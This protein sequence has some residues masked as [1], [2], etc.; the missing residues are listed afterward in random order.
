MLKPSSGA[1]TSASAS[2]AAATA[3]RQQL[4]AIWRKLYGVAMDFT[5]AVGGSSSSSS[6]AY[7]PLLGL[8]SVHSKLHVALMQF[9]DE[10]LLA[11][12]TR[13]GSNSSSNSTSASNSS[14]TSSDAASRGGRRGESNFSRD[15][16]AEGAGES[17]SDVSATDPAQL[18]LLALLQGASRLSIQMGLPFTM[19]THHKI[20]RI[21]A[22][23][24]PFLALEH[25]NRLV[26]AGQ[27]AGVGGSR[28]AA[29]PG[30]A[31]AP[32]AAAQ[33][34]KGSASPSPLNVPFIAEPE[35]IDRDLLDPIVEG[36]LK[37]N[38]PDVAMLFLHQLYPLGRSDHHD[39]QSAAQR[40]HKSGDNNQPRKLAE[41][42]RE[43]V[44]ALLAKLHAAE[45]PDA[46]SAAL[47]AETDLNEATDVVPDMGAYDTPLR[48][49]TVAGVA[50]QWS[51]GLAV[52]DRLRS[53]LPPGFDALPLTLP[54]LLAFETMWT[55]ILAGTD[56][57]KELLAAEDKKK[58]EEKAVR[59][60]SK[61]A[62]APSAVASVLP[63]EASAEDEEGDEEEGED[64]EGEGD[65]DPREFQAMMDMWQQ[66][67]SKLES[68]TISG[69]DI[70]GAVRAWD[71]QTKVQFR[72]TVQLWLQSI[73][74]LVEC[75]SH[76]TAW[77]RLLEM[78]RS[79]V[80]Q[81]M[82]RL[83]YD[84]FYR[85]AER[86]VEAQ[87]KQEQ[88]AKRAKAEGGAGA[89]DKG[90]DDDEEEDDDEAVPQSLLDA[91]LDPRL[92]L[93]ESLTDAQR[94]EVYHSVQESL[95][96]I[97]QRLVVFPVEEG[98]H[99]YELVRRL[100]E[101]AMAHY[102]RHEHVTAGPLWMQFKP[103]E[104]FAICATAE[105]VLRDKA[106]EEAE[107]DEEEEEKEEGEGAKKPASAP[108]AATVAPPAQQKQLEL[109]PF[110]VRQLTQAVVTHIGSQPLM[111]SQAM[112]GF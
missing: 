46:V 85:A 60:A 64:E 7:S 44:G 49:M 42:A 40:L 100:Q 109:T 63:K 110:L 37:A 3:R 38:R 89:T 95:R 59:A 84:L 86:Q 65:I 57:V 102:K 33:G 10:L 17:L 77:D 79:R 12:T 66:L 52:T 67:S 18:E 103:A 111:S 88:A 58:G 26:M 53:L 4:P 2:A 56:D 54:L 107:E 48:R 93:L 50:G 6:P 25:L 112:K 81:H 45:D 80:Y 62:N 1:A 97:S 23:R 78:N 61:A 43:S 101:D 74:R 51:I 24:S 47:P 8:G 39:E 30:P 68:G 36:F 34:S 70:A 29:T 27:G 32:T 19:P 82:V 96:R 91:L 75:Q 20:M 98:A 5:R 15:S 108:V 72:R 9:T 28:A 11:I 41:R 14:S 55:D 87:L 105:D 35:F 104:E 106:E 69:S 99:L 71:T 92:R 16:G 90:E 21:L 13:Q 83:T 94:Q 76:I 22:K 73:A 31:T